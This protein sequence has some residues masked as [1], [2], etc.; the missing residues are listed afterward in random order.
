MKVLCNFVKLEFWYF[1]FV[2]AMGVVLKVFTSKSMT[3][4]VDFV[5]FTRNFIWT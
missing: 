5:C 3:T 4:Y 1:E 2:K